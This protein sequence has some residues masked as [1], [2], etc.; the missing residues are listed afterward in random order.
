VLPPLMVQSEGG[1]FPSDNRLGDVDGDGLPEMAVGRI[2][3]LS[4]AELDAFTG[5]IAAYEGAS[6]ESWTA[7]A[8]LLADAT[9]LGADFVADNERIASRLPAPFQVDRIYLPSI[10]LADARSQLMNAIGSG[11]S[12]IN[13][14]GHGAIDRLSGSGLLTS[15]DV[16]GLANGERLPVLTAMTCTVNRFAVPG[17]PAL[18]EVLVKSPS[19]GAAAVWGPSGL[20][21]HHD[22][23][24]L[25]E[26][27]YA[28]AEERLGDRVLAAI[29]AFRAAGGDPALP[30]IYDVL[31]D[32]ALKL[33]APPVPPP[34]GGS[35]GE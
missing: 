19:G 8:V 16:P 4:A 27:F 2:P 10:A 12:F 11:T 18:G 22:A 14:M 15:A 7:N 29:A 25:A 5:K 1:L 31:G 28:G 32:P 6:T 3:V 17:V 33:P 26:S 24:L 13:Y 20:S 30:V 35:A 9:D 34:S 23:R 21:F